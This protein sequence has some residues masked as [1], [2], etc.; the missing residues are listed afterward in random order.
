MR[1]AINHVRFYYLTTS[2]SLA[3][4]KRQQDAHEADCTSSG[5]IA[6]N[7]AWWQW[8]LT[9]PTE[10]AQYSR[11]G[12]IVDVMTGHISVFAVAPET[13]HAT[14]DQSGI[15]FLE[16]FLRAKAHLFENTRSERINDDVNMWDEGFDERDSFSAFGIDCHRALMPCELVGGRRWRIGSVGLWMSAIQAKNGRTI[17]SK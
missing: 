14:N 12:N 17:V 13:R 7:V 3:L 9:L 5:K 10:H 15:Q 2:C 6:Q 4:E 16:H 1:R 8:W 11:N